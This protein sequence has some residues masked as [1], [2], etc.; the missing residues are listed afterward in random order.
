MSIISET[1]LKK[2]RIEESKNPISNDEIQSSKDLAEEQKN[3]DII[4]KVF[5]S[6]QINFSKIEDLNNFKKILYQKE[7]E[8]SKKIAQIKTLV[9]ETNKN[10]AKRCEEKHKKHKWIRERENCMYGSTFTIC[11]NCRIDYYDR[12]Y[13][14]Y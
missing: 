3:E 11:E 2:R 13:M 14:H 8:Y 5:E 7:S 1:N 12:T 10:I 4:E 9:K 6:N